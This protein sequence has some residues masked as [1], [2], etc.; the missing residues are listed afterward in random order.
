MHSRR[1]VPQRRTR[2]VA[3]LALGA[4]VVLGASIA[5]AI[6]FNQ[7]ASE[8]KQVRAVIENRFA[9]RTAFLVLLDQDAGISGYVAT[10]DRSF[11]ASF[12]ANA[13]TY[14]ATRSRLLG[15]GDPLVT[16][17][18]RRFVATADALEPFFAR[19]AALVRSGQVDRARAG[20]RA[21]RPAFDR[22]RRTERET[23]AAFEAALATSRAVARAAFVTAEVLTSIMG[24]VLLLA[25]I[26]GAVLIA[27][28]RR[29]R[30]LANS[31]ELTGLPNRRAF[32]AR[33]AAA[34][35]ARGANQMVG[36][37]YL[38]LDH[39]KEVNDQFGHAVGDEILVRV[40]RRLGRAL[41]PPDV[42][43]RLSGD[44]FGVLLGGLADAG[45]APFVAQRVDD[46]LNRP[47]ALGE[48]Q[49]QVGASIGIAIAPQDG[50][51]PEELLAVADAAMYR[52]KPE[53][54]APGP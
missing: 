12:D 41:R 51:T 7:S 49:L 22:L 37:L 4:V 54:D 29:D 21:A 44:E 52:A 40:A 6:A 18:L 46:A 42:A 31:D 13:A 14:A 30:I 25:G 27:G 26:A 33:L 36:L 20:L 24:F 45:Q 15:P 5:T 50:E 10:G 1:S 11:L 23:A 3:G 19:E 8:G 32:L 34:L 43:F 9:A 53:R 17:Q 48:R 47:F 39:F 16:V 2:Y 35:R 28:A 38:D